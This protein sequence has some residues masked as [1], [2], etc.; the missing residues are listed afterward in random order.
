MNT[1][2]LE[3]LRV[4][5]YRTLRDLEL[6]ELTPLAVFLGPNGSGKSTLMDVFAFLAECFNDGLRRAW[7]RRGRFKELRSR[8]AGEGENIEITLGYQEQRH[9]LT[10]FVRE[11]QLIIGE[12]QEG[13]YVVSEKLF[14]EPNLPAPLLFFKKG[15]GFISEAFSLPN[16][17]DPVPSPQEKILAA[18][19]IL[20]VNTFGQLT[21]YPEIVALR[22][23][24][25]R[26]HLA[27]ISAEQTRTVPNEG[28]REHLSPTGANL[29]NVLQYLQE[30][31]PQHFADILQR[32][33]ERVP[34]LATVHTE[35]TLDG[36]LLL[37]IKDAPF[38]RPI[39]AKYASDGTL[40]LLAYLVLLYDPAPPPLIAIEELE[41]DLHHR[42][43]SR[44]VEDCLMA[45]GRTQL[46][47]T[48]HSPYLVDALT[49]NEVWLLY[50]DEQ[51]YTQAHRALDLPAIQDLLNEGFKLGDLW[52]SGEFRVGDPLYR[53]KALPHR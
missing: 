42:L 15:R 1:P 2:R 27:Q 19:D 51:G 18:S 46:F 6:R 47:L 11:Y 23:F 24:I 45:S 40:K 14:S 53:Q 8:G 35:P 52:R 3:Y 9:P 29:A 41:N 21:S 12:N 7:E 30:Q 36:R 44:L 34:L 17:N 39:M 43:L 16:D 13:P 5:N 33:T 20:A 31:Q 28:A 25:T 49:A 37:Q 38:E 32:L 50:R 4:K 10:T 22:N 48:T 26:W